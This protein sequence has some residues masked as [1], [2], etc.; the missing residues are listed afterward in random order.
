MTKKIFRSIIYVSTA[1]FLA[2]LLIITGFFYNYFAELQK[3]QLRDELSL[4]ALGIEQNGMEYITKIDSRHY[5]MTWIDSDGTVL[6]DT[7]ADEDKMENHLNREEIQEAIKTGSGSSYRYSA[8]L[9]ENTLYEAVLLS[10]GTVLRISI[11]QKSAL[12]LLFGL[13]QPFIIILVI[14]VCISRFL[15][16]GVARQ[17]TEP[18]NQINLE[19]PLENNTYEEL[20][21]LLNRIYHQQNQITAQMQELQQ[22]KQEFEQ[23]TG[24]M[25]EGLVL[26][27]VQNQV[28]SINPAALAL[29]QTTTESVGKEFFRIDR[30]QNINT[31]IEKAMSEGHCEIRIEKN[32]RE[33]QFDI[34]RIESEGENIGTVILAFDITEQANAERIRREFSANVSHELKTPLQS[35]MGSSELIENGLVRQEDLPRFAGHIHKEASRLVLLI[36]DIIRLSQ[37]DENHKLQREEIVLYDLVSEVFLSLQGIAQSRGISLKIEGNKGTILG[38]QRLFYEIIYNLCD[39]AIKYNVDHGEVKVIISED[40]NEVKIAVQD[41]G[42][43]IPAEHHSRVFERFYRVDK[44][45]SKKTG[46]T[47]LGLSIVKHAVHYHGG[48]ITL[49]SE[50]GKGTCIQMIFPCL[51]KH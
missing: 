44:S 8:T 48:T 36:E 12:A 37:L 50:A 35:I 9:T 29:F 7:W 3:N 24:H 13:F 1:V 21:P 25:K 19:Y 30:K 43:G 18:L 27:N 23:I 34:S 26:L 39:N 20:A 2:S 47:G 40:E 11:S 15:A 6:F 42:I 45:H 32:G 28:L 38:V 14:A 49:D 17:I 51:I 46:G 31:A 4:A 33:Y 22:R 41:T 16:K 10:D 5:R